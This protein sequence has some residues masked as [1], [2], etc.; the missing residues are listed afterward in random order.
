MSGFD[1]FIAK[2]YKFSFF[3]HSMSVSLKTLGMVLVGFSIALLL[4]LTFVK[5]KVDQ[6][7]TL[8]CEK[9]HENQ[10][11]MDQNPVHKSSLSWMI[12]SAFGIAFLLMGLGGYMFFL[13]QQHS[14]ATFITPRKEFK[15]ADLGTFDEEEK[16]VYEAIR[17]KEGSAFQ[18]D[19]IKD[20][21][22]SK[23][24]VTRILDRLE[25][26]EILER[27]RRGMTNIIVLK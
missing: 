24:K 18:S 23:V 3:P 25:M 9:L 12:V 21:G 1:I 5:V 16:K 19:L 11:T 27:K 20:T 15:E 6:E 7:S 17:G 14:E 26:K 13:P 8:L 10:I 4:I 2:I 22:F